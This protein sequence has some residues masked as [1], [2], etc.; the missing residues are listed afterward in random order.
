MLP[1]TSLEIG[2]NGGARPCCLYDEQIPEAKVYEQS[3]D[4]IQ[5]SEYMNNL[6]QKFKEGERPE[7]CTRCWSEEDAGKVSKRMHTFYKM[8][9]SLDNW[10]PDSEPQL[11][12]I[13]FKLGNVCNL[14]CRICGSWS[15][16]KWAKEEMDYGP[17][18][19]AEKNLKE[20]GWPKREVKFFTDIQP[21]LQ[22]VEFFEFTGGEP[23][24]IQNHFKILEH[25]VE[26]Y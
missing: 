21:V 23:F 6:R 26:K 10:T 13:D 1:W 16:S 8:N 17:N 19:F 4:K 18:P 24:M 22:H 3:L 14:K 20:G 9:V 12:F 2:V 15:S 11:K 25:C 5:K 7:M